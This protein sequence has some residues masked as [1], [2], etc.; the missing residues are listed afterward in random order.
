[1]ACG[2]PVIGSR[3]GAVP[4]VIEDGV[5]GVIVENYREMPAALERAD[6]LD[7]L[8]IRRYVENRFSQER[9]VSDYVAAYQQLLE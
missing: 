2:T 8:E 1:M 6:A 5:S 9:M 3:R 4:E 7:P